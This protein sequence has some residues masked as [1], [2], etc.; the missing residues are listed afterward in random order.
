MALFSNTARTH[1]VGK[2]CD[3][4]ILYYDD[5]S[6]E[7]QCTVIT[8]Q[9]GPLKGQWIVHGREAAWAQSYQKPQ[10]QPLASVTDRSVVSIMA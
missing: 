4:V 6:G 9:Q 2:T 5:G 7:Q 10:G 3:W 1:Q 8:S